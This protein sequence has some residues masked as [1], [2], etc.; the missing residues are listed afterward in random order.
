MRCGRGLRRGLVGLV[1][2]SFR[3]FDGIAV[4][5]GGVFGGCKRRRAG[6]V[7]YWMGFV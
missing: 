4:F 3:S 7:G 5:I 2:R 6:R 1:E